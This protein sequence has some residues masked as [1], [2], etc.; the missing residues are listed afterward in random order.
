MYFD[1]VLD[2]NLHPVFNGTPEATREWLHT[3]HQ[4]VDIDD[5]QVC[6]GKSLRMFSVSEYLGSQK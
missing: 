2:R 6:V 4:R 3:N 1:A 5:L